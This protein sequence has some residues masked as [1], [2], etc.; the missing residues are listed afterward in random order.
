MNRKLL[1]YLCLATLTQCSKCKNDPAPTDPA[2]ALPPATQTGAN[3]FGCLVNGQPYTPSGNNG[4][5]NY[6]VLYD[7]GFQ[8]G[9]LQVMTYRYPEAR[10]SKKQRVSLGGINIDHVGTYQLGSIYGTGAGFT[11]E[12]RAAPCDEYRSDQSG[13]YAK[14]AIVITRLDLQAG[15]LS[16]TFAFALAQPGC[17]TV[18]VTQGRFDKKL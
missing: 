18:K 5:A 12:Y 16:G 2:A 6:A 4:T 10:V 11:D 14:G 8:G 7:P 15:I 9:N 3:T 17:D 13:G 1:L